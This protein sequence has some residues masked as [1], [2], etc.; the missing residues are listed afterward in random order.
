MFRYILVRATGQESDKPVFD[1]ALAVA[2][3]SAA[4]LA[5]LHVGIDVEQAALAIISGEYA[6][7]SGFSNTIESLQQRATEQRNR[8]AQIFRAFC[9]D[10]GLPIRSQP[11]D[12]TVSAEW[13]VEAGSEPG[14]LAMCG[15]AADL[16]VLGRTREGGELAMDVLEA[17]LVETGRP[18]LLA[19]PVAPPQVGRVVAI[20]WKDTREAA[21]AV[22]AAQPFIRSAERII[23]ICVVEDEWQEERSYE[24]LRHALTW[25]NPNVVVRR[26]ADRRPEHPAEML[27]AEAASESADLL[28]M[29]G[30]SH[31]RMREVIFGGVTR[32]ILH[33][34]DLP[35]LIAH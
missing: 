25:H 9:A 3:I 13:L 11:S 27:L 35:V 4:H 14:L 26:R 31:S 8:A 19:P 5:F 1:T 17:A 28:V 12:E 29:G 18:V 2:G 32:R 20:A 16:L 22:A 24:R 6:D 21:R 30:Y 33:G 23:V 34:A 10:K 7:G 15:R